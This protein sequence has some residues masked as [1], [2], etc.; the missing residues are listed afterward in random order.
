MTDEQRPKRE[1]LPEVLTCVLGARGYVLDEIRDARRASATAGLLRALRTAQDGCDPSTGTGWLEA[2]PIRDSREAWEALCTAF[3]LA[4]WVDDPR[5]RFRCSCDGGRLSPVFEFTPTVVRV[6]EIFSELR[7]AG[8][9]TDR[10]GDYPASIHPADLDVLSR[11]PYVRERRQLI[12]DGLG[13][14]L[15][16]LLLMPTTDRGRGTV[17][18]HHPDFDRLRHAACSGTGA[19]AQP[20]TVVDCVAFAS[21]VPGVLRAEALARDLSG[22]ARVV[23]RV[24]DTVALIAEHIQR[25]QRQLS[26]ALVPP[27]EPKPT[28]APSYDPLADQT[29]DENLASRSKL[30]PRMRDLMDTGYV[31][32]ENADAET[33][34]LAAPPL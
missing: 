9:P 27:A 10:N 13:V 32:D 6:R 31:F 20:A 28:G 29:S 30:D 22:R 23:W 12:D 16:G 14:R 18:V 8:L 5:R 34:V 17:R 21:D 26:V 15:A 11:E 7:H 24:V 25:A 2:E 4:G 19:Q 1:R 3:D 33:V